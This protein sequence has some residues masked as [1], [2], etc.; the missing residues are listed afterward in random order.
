M[1]RRERGGICIF[2][3]T[4]FKAKKNLKY[5]YYTVLNILNNLEHLNIFYVALYKK[6]KILKNPG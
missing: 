5:S 6:I 2:I 3:S 1:T 4:V